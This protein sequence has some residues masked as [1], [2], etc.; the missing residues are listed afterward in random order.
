MNRYSALHSPRTSPRAVGRSAQNRGSL[1]SSV[2][3]GLR[4]TITIR[5]QAARRAASRRCR[6][7]S[8]SSARL[9]KALAAMIKESGRSDLNAY[10]AI[11]GS[12]STITDEGRC[13]NVATFLAPGALSSFDLE[14]ELFDLI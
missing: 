5:I 6:V 2:P 4:R 10:C 3:N 1:P 14:D 11:S 12:E 7:V 13:A 8:R 9:T